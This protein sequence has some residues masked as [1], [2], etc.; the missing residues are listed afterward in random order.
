MSRACHLFNSQEGT[1][2]AVARR[3]QGPFIVDL[4]GT[5]VLGG[6]PSRGDV[7]LQERMAV[8]AVSGV[9]ACVALHWQSAEEV[10]HL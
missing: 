7:K 1:D 9:G 2:Q 10:P 8:A 5:C 6:G 3:S 4:R